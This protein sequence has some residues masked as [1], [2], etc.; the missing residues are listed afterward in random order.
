MIRH[1]IFPRRYP[2]SRE[3]AAAIVVRTRCVV[4][5][6]LAFA[7]AC[8]AVSG[9]ASASAAPAFTNVTAAAGLTHI[10][11]TQSGTEPMSGG[12]A[13]GDFKGDGLVDLFFTRPGLPDVMYRN[14]GNGTFVDVSTQAGFT[15]VHNGT[16]VAAGDI[17]NEG[18]LDLYTTATSHN[19]FYMYLNDGAGHFTEDAVARGAAVRAPARRRGAA[20]GSRWETTT[21]TGIST[22]SPATIADR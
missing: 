7:L 9:H 2:L 3:C 20:W 15:Q 22:S 12:A 11:S 6:R 17:D 21:A 1:R 14:A 13:A 8:L 19:R 16:G 18:D 4:R 10:H 5:W